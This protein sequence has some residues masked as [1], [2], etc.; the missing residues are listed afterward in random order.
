MKVVGETVA[1][2]SFIQVIGA[3]KLTSPWSFEARSISVASLQNNHQISSSRRRARTYPKSVCTAQSDNLLIVE[4]LTI[5]D[6]SKTGQ[7]SN[8]LL[9]LS[10]DSL[11][12][13]LVTIWQTSVRRA[14]L[15]E[16]ILPSGSPWHDRSLHFLNSNHTAER[17]KVRVLLTSQLTAHTEEESTHSHFRELLLDLFYPLTS[18]YQPSIRAMVCFR[19][20]THSSTV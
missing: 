19:S 6:R 7:I 8:H 1:P 2:I 3:R 20:E 13:T 9:L 12:A 11:V 18:V 16:T 15:N 10:R 17:P 5:E 14:V 4:A